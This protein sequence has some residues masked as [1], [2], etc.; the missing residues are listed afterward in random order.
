MLKMFNFKLDRRT[1]FNILKIPAIICLRIP[2]CLFFWFITWLNDW[3]EVINDK[4][5]GWDQYNRS[6]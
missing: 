5:P 6:K 3:S 4:L 1:A 2:V